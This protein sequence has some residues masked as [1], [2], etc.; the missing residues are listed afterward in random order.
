MGKQFLLVNQVSRTNLL[1]LQAPQILVDRLVAYVNE[2]E[3]GTAFMAA[4]AL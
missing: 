3:A 2:Q 1:A 4:G